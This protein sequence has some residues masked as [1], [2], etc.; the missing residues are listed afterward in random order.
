MTMQ[1]LPT[2]VLA[3]L[4]ITGC[5]SVAVTNDAIEQRTAATLGLQPGTFT[6][7]DRVNDGVQSRYNVTTKHGKH[8]NCYVTGAMSYTGRVVSDAICNEA[9]KAAKTSKQAEGAKECNA[10]LKAAGK[11]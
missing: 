7:S 4:T 5:A 1:L 11:C 2:L 6:I 8:Y 3:T 9:G 10:L